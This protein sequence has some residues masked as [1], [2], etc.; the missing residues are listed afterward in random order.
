MTGLADGLDLAASPILRHVHSIAPSPRIPFNLPFAEE[1]D[2]PKQE[3]RRGFTLI[4]LLVVI[5]II[6]VLIAL[7]LPAV[8]AAREAARRAQCTNNLKQLGLAVHNYISANNVFPLGSYQKP[9]FIT[10]CGSTHEQSFLVGLTNYFEQQ[11]VYNAY[12]FSVNAYDFSN[13]TI[14][15]VGISTLWCPSDPKVSD[16]QDLSASITAATGQ[17]PPP[18]QLMHYNSYKGN[19][20]TWFAPGLSDYPTDPTFA[21]AKAE[22]NGL[23]YFYSNNSIASVTDGTSNT[24][25]IAESAYG[26]LG[27]QDAIFFGWWTSGDYGDT[28]FTTLYPINPQSKLGGNPNTTVISIDTFESAASSFHPGGI[29]VGFA[30]GSVRFIKDSISTLPFSQATGLPTALIATANGSCADSAPLYSFQAGTQFGVW[31]ALSTRA[32]GE[33]IG[34]DSY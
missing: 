5:A 31:Q 32:G 2:M 17:S 11:Q 19:S 21:A 27:G 1:T 28:M 16:V 14:H 10:A 23:I 7:L 30:D 9:Q 15:G 20:G 12:N 29:N 3:I 22:A 13:L 6:A 24:I 18:I 25:L 4:E 26:K 33:V 34:S 8:Q